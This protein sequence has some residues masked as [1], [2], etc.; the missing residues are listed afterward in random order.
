MH[1]DY[2][3]ETTENAKKID[4]AHKVIIRSLGLQDRVFKTTNRESFISLKDH[5]EGFKNTPSCR[6]LNPT[7]CEIGRISHQ[8]LSKIE[9]L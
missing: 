8:I 7:K 5:K 6:L 3:K 2:K 4:Q 1:K 9:Q